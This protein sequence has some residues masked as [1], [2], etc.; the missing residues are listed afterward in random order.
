MRDSLFMDEIQLALKA[1]KGGA[2]WDAVRSIFPG[3]DP[4]ALDTKFKESLYAKAD[5]PLPD[6]TALEIAGKKAAEMEAQRAQTETEDEK[7][8]AMVAADIASKAAADVAKA[9][10]VKGKKSDPLG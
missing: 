4:V 5:L 7:L 9:A 1:I 10:P 2:P 8:E 3:V 6:P